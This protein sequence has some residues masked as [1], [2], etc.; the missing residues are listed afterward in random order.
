MTDQNLA[1]KLGISR[2]QVAFRRKE[3]GIVPFDRK[4]KDRQWLDEED[5]MLG[6]QIDMEVAVFLKIS[7]LEVSKRRRALGKQKPD[8]S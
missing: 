1:G 6:V 5:A 3:M 8:S 7:R 4:R 2:A